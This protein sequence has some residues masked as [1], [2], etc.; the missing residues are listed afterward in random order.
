MP[1]R[2]GTFGSP[3]FQRQHQSP[4]KEV[5]SDLH[6]LP[7]EN[8]PTL[9]QRARPWINR[10][11]GFQHC[12][13]DFCILVWFQSRGFKTLRSKT[14]R[15]ES[16]VDGPAES[17]PY[18]P[19]FMKVRLVKIVSNKTERIPKIISLLPSQGL[20][21]KEKGPEVQLL[22]QIVKQKSLP[23]DQQE[24]FKTGFSEGFMRSQAFT[25]RTQGVCPSP[26]QLLAKEILT[27]FTLTSVFPQTH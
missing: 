22:D 23:D 4:L 11:S 3:L 1:R 9:L 26:F 24:A 15:A 10:A 27:N 14:R 2:V 20:L 25:Q 17:E 8:R 6:F 19:A 16:S 12:I 18:T 13:F 5:C 7:G 21:Q